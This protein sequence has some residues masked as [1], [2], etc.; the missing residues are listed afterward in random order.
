MMTE[1][2]RHG[3][4]WTCTDIG[5]LC[6]LFGGELV[7]MDVPKGERGGLPDWPLRVSLGKAALLG[8]SKDFLP[9]AGGMVWR[10]C[11]SVWLLDVP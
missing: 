8:R 3:E 4:D 5:R 6:E 7:L 11:P 1:G 2:V 10:F 9:S